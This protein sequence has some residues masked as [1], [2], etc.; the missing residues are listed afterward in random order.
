VKDVRNDLA[1]GV[2]SFADVGRNASPSDLEL[3]RTQTVEIL[4]ETLQNIES[5]LKRQEYLSN[6]QP[7]A[8]N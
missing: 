1:H 7:V 5:Y 4:T 8:R 3:A 6:P 2:K